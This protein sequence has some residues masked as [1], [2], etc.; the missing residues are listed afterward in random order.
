MQN[1]KENQTRNIATG[2]KYIN[3]SK[4]VNRVSIKVKLETAKVITLAEKKKC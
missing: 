1:R 4:G 2:T 3:K